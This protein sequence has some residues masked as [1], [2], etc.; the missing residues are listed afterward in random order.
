MIR[1]LRPPAANP[2]RFLPALGLILLVSVARCSQN[3]GGH[4]NGNGP[5][6]E[7]GAHLK[8]LAGGLDVPLYL[9]SPPNDPRLFIV[10][11]GGV[12][13]IVEGGQ[14]LGAPFLDV[15]TL[16]SNGSEQGLLSMAFHPGYAGNGRFFISYTDVN[17]VSRVVEYRVSSDPNRAETAP[18]RTIIGVDQP[19]SNHNGGLILFGRDGKLYFGLGDGGGAGD[20]QENGQNLGTLLGK[21]LRIDVDSG[22]P[23]AIPPDNPFV[24]RA[25]VK[26]EIWA[27]GLRNPWRFSFD[28]ANGDIY[29]ADVG[30]WDWEEVDAITASSLG[31]GGQ[32]Y[33]WD[34][35]E[36]SHCFEPPSGCDSTGLVLP[37]VEYDHSGQN[38][39]IT[40][41]YC[42]RGNLLTG[43]TG[44]YFYADY[45]AGFVRSFKLVNG[46]ATDER[47]WPDLAPPDGFVT[48]FGEDAEGE[49]Y[50]MSGR[51]NAPGSGK[52]YAIVPE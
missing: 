4:G 36:G 22:V 48:S 20:P 16:V 39:S 34:I 8:L 40:G 21:I 14:L 29:I 3:A 11:K 27:Y 12:I 1:H 2:R 50:I 44:H 46:R 30:Q 38:C 23:Y 47:S 33:G 45:C 43:L 41:G 25:G 9:T 10:E 28:R 13:R 26:E 24:G 49:I 31:H 37:V 17:G 51:P 6:P 19:F 15:T 7:S 32:N 42:Y 5:P 35:L 52:V 18:V